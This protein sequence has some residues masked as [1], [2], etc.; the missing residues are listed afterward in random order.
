MFILPSLPSVEIRFNSLD[1]SRR[2]DLCQPRGFSRVMK[3]RRRG[4]WVG[5]VFAVGK[6]LAGSWG[7]GGTRK[8]LKGTRVSEG[9]GRGIWD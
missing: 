8:A 7:A 9:V 4:C 3:G 5:A 1:L 2:L 6:G